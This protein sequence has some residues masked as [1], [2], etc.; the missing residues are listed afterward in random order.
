MQYVIIG[1]GIAGTTAAE[2]LRKA[3]EMAEITIIDEEAHACYSRVLLPHYITGKVLRDKVFLRSEKWYVEQRIERLAGTIV[4]GIDTKNNFVTIHTGRE[5]PY[6]K[7][8]LA[9][10]GQLNLAVTDPKGV[11]YL[12]TLDDADGIVARLAE[13]KRLPVPQ[14]R[15]V[16]IGGGFISLEFINIFAQFNLPTTVVLRGDGF[17]SRVLSTQAKEV[18]A[19]QAV[20]KGVQVLTGQREVLSVGESEVSGVQLGDG[21]VLPASIVGVGL[22]THADKSLFEEA[23]VLMKS[24]ILANSYLETNVPN[25]YAAGDAAEF[26]H[27][28][29][30]RQMHIGNWLNAQMQGKAVA[31]TM[32]GERTEFSLVSSYS[33]NLLGLHVVFIGDTNREFAGE[34]RSHKATETSSVDLYTRNDKIVGAVLVGDLV[35]R[36]AITKAIQEQRS[37]L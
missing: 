33:T 28:L 27:P 25:V 6:D 9:T 18:L 11:C 14:Q 36:A 10:G 20:N 31:K 30:G 21:T 23:G 2:E 3:D 16:I 26:E 15:A 8:L 7:L 24:G 17:W 19:R 37:T 12:Q 32:T 1:G 5:L 4:T 29:L 22:G 34:V 13:V 35:D